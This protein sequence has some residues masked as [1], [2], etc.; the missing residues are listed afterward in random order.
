LKIAVDTNVLLR[1]ALQDD[2]AQSPIA[3]KT[4]R[5]AEIVFVATAA[6]CE[7]VW[8]LRKVYQRTPA[9]IALSIRHLMNTAN[10][11]MNR[12]AIEAGL[13]VLE[14]GGDFADGAIAGEAE[15]L[16]AGEFVTFDKKAATLLR[17][18]GKRAR[19]LA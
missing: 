14:K 11:E 8:V 18:K 3:S 1:D 6:L 15:R 17:S 2:P 16:G 10:V 5:S 9:E 7:F 19:L 4:L 12:F 13:G